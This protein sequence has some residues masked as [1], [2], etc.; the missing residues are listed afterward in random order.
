LWP[1]FWAPLPD[2][3]SFGR[4][5]MGRRDRRP[6][7]F[8]CVLRPKVPRVRALLRE[9]GSGLKLQGTIM[10]AFISPALSRDQVLGRLS[11]K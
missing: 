4:A 3:V 10:G 8:G 6:T 1:F 2:A 7:S 5:A 9:P 11:L